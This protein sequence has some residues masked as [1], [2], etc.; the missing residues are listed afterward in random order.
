[1]LNATQKKHRKHKYAR[2]NLFATQTK[3]LIRKFYTVQYLKKINS[4][5]LITFN[6]NY[7]ME[8][9]IRKVNMLAVNRRRLRLNLSLYRYHSQINNA[10]KRKVCLAI[11]QIIRN[12]QMRLTYIFYELIKEVINLVKLLEKNEREKVMPIFHRK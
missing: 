6:I 10:Y 11:I 2:S 3:S 8:I 1:M 4:K 12:R 5:R 9:L 7:Q